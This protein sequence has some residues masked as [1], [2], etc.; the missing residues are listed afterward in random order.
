MKEQQAE[1]DAL[2]EKNQRMQDKKLQIACSYMLNSPK[3]EIDEEAAKANKLDYEFNRRW[4]A[5]RKRECN[6]V[7]ELDLVREFRFWCYL[8]LFGLHSVKKC[9]FLFPK[10]CT[11]LCLF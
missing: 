6:Y 11:Y 8:T 4:N 3:S 1:I 9:C 7:K 10:A 2:K 5:T